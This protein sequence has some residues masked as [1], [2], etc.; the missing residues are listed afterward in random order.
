MEALG[1]QHVQGSVGA[2]AAQTSALYSVKNKL[3]ALEPYSVFPMHF[4]TR[5]PAA[6][7][8]IMLSLHMSSN[9]SLETV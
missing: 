3:S 7:H 6:Q 2:E 1:R 4:L 9:V 8:F 5:D